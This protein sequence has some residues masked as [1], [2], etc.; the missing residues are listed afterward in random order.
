MV[1]KLTSNEITATTSNWLHIGGLEFRQEVVDGP[2]D[3]PR[4]WLYI[5][6]PK[7]TVRAWDIGYITDGYYQQYP[8]RLWEL[9]ELILTIIDGH[10]HCCLSGKVWNL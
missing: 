3:N 9:Y 5:Q 1:A 7:G 2:L 6:G 4:C 10:Y 8:D